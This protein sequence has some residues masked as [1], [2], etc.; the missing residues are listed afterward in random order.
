VE[1]VKVGVVGAGFFGRFHAEKVAAMEGAELVG[2]SDVDPSRAEEVA[3]RCRTRPFS[4]HR[5]LVGQVQAVSIA[6]PT[7]LHYAV[8]ADFLEQGVDVLLEKPITRTLEEA[9]ELIRMAEA[10]GLILQVGQ[11]ERFNGALV[12]SRE[13]VRSPYLFESHR[14]SPFPGRGADV[15]VVLD[16]MI[17]DIDA[18]LSLVSQEVRAVKATGS[19]VVTPLLDKVEA[20]VEFVNG[21]VARM[22]ASRVAEE[23]VRQTRIHQADGVITIDYLSQKAFLLPTVPSPAG[24]ESDAIPRDLAAQKVDLLEA[25]IR[26]FVRSVRDRR[27]P[28]VSGRD[29][30]RALEVA[31]KI[32]ESASEDPRRVRK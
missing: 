24:G 23:K 21:C 14:S 11:L 6:V 12:A 4:D 1:R 20:R 32:A 8:A 13:I 27:P 30:K 15:D 28:F 22:K 16:L 26:S 9:D 29:G 3:R 31:L 7:R 17:H 18:L 19:P 5:D 2:V 25:E 10:R